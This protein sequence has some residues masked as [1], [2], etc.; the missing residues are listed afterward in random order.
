VHRRAFIAGVALAAV[1]LQAVPAASALPAGAAAVVRARFAASMPERFGLDADGDGR[2]D[3]PNS[4]EY[5]QGVRSSD[6]AGC[7]ALFRLRLDAGATTATMGPQA[8][9]ILSYRWE[10]AGEGRRLVRRGPASALEVEL[11][12]GRYQV[13]L[14]VEA[15][16]PWGTV[17]GRAGREVRVED[18]L[19]VALGDSYAAGEG[20]PE[21]AQ[22]PGG[23]AAVWAD[24]PGDP[25]AEAAHAAAHRSTAA[26]P[27][28]AAL[29]LERADAATSVTFI[30]LAATTASVASGV[31]GAQPGVAETSQLEQ[32][33]EVVGGRRIDWL[34][35]SVGGNDI[36]FARIVR[37]LVDADRL[38]DPVCYGTDLENIFAAAQDGDW[39]RGSALRFS[40]PWGVGCRSTRT[41]GGPMLPGLAG[42]PSELDR[43]ADAVETTLDPAAVFLME[44]PD[45]T[46]SGSGDSGCEEIV[47]DVTPP[48]GFHEIS[49]SEQELGLARVVEPLN[50]ALAEAAR[51]HGW[52]IVGGVASA[53]AAGHGYCGA[54]PHYAGGSAGAGLE[55]AVD[56]WYRHPASPEADALSAEAGVSW[57]RTAGQSVA[58][59]GPAS[60]W[61]TMGTLHPNELGQL[62][63][64]RA[65]LALVSD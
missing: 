23:R 20:N 25:G 46:G 33:A 45:P 39:S 64:A 28:L 58:L 26:W 40:L 42:L 30:S 15:A 62:A 11:P 29:A 47:G 35:L 55:A 22:E 38:A 16:L 51:R 31:L 14:E 10:I 5:A 18:L 24:A 13:S 7:P 37:G 63:M 52:N 50:R 43:L 27:A 48:F 32:V 12:E 2:L 54:T 61:D 49:R 60:A 44:Y 4:A 65:L 21:G 8:L 1:S 59:Q 17:R 34:L 53:F 36:G 9:P 6:C 41:S 3:M 56:A 57:Y 19:I